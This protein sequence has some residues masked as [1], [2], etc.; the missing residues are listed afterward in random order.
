MTND[1]ERLLSRREVEALFGLSVRFL[2]AC[3]IR[4]D[5]PPMIRVSS[6]MVR[7][8]ATEIEA[9]LDRKRVGVPADQRGAGS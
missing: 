5:G 4:G 7:Y 9:W 8:R 1:G 2:E 3:A 6:R